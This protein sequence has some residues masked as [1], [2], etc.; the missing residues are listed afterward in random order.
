MQDE[1]DYEK[2]I[3]KFGM[4]DFDVSNINGNSNGLDLTNLSLNKSNNLFNQSLNVIL[5]NVGC[6]PV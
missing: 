6:R 2:E 1:K 4:N 5:F 3:N